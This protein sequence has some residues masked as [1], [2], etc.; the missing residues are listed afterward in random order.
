MTRSNWL[1]PAVLL[2]AVTGTGV[3]L[4]AWKHSSINEANASA[5]QPEPAETVT[6]ALARPHR[7]QPTTTA[8]GTVLALRS[9]TLR[10]EMP[11]TVSRVAFNPGEV[12][13][14]G[15]VLVELDVSVER[16]EL[17]AQEA[18]ANLAE[19]VHHRMLRLSKTGAVSQEQLDRA[20]AEHEV[21][22]AQVQ[23]TK[24]IIERKTIRA[25][26]RARVGIADTHPGQYLNEGTPLTTLQGVAESA[27]V[28]FPVSQQVAEHLGAGDSVEIIG[29]DG[30][31]EAS[32]VAIDARVDAA[33][34]N[35]VIRAKVE[36]ASALPAPGASVQVRIP[37]GPSHA[38][39]TIPASSL[40][41]G[42]GGDQV[43]VLAPGEDGNLRAHARPVE[44][45]AMLGDEVVI[46][47]GLSA[48][49]RVAASGSFKLRDAVLVAV[50]GEALVSSATAN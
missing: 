13:E 40:R 42:P 10:N 6:E 24:A 34:R 43:F 12:V 47:N 39:V 50:S 37:V 18:Q 9:I 49:E 2:L 26:F 19:T 15:A 22:L 38:A 23:R 8:I 44:V 20:R 31:I 4:A 30:T 17:A 48:G 41:R 21:A 7:H 11:G 29:T 1:A 25:P 36:D 3:G 35:T 16:A 46:N 33:T 14:A 5:Q 32:I 27:Q 28:D 45:G